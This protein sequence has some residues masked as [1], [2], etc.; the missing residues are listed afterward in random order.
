MRRIRFDDFE[1]DLDL[2]TLSKNGEKIHIGPRALDLL[3]CLTENRERVVSLDFLQR[4]VWKAKSL[5]AA[6]IPTAIM[7]IRRALGDSATAPSFISSTRGRG[8]RFLKDVELSQTQEETRT[9]TISKQLP[10]VGRASQ[11]KLLKQMSDQLVSHSLGRIVVLTGE[12]GIGKTRLLSEFMDSASERVSWASA[13]SPK[14]EGC[15]P[16]WLWTHLLRDVNASGRFTS[17]RLAIFTQALARVFPEVLGPA[18]A[19]FEPPQSIAKFTVIDQWISAIRSM[20]D[21]GPLILTF[22]DIHRADV[23]S[24][25]L[26]ACLAEEVEQDPILIL[27][28][29]RPPTK[30]D[31]KAYRIAEIASAQ[32]AVSMEV[33]ALSASE[34][35]SLFE[36]LRDDREITGEALHRRTRGNAFY[37]SRVIQHFGLDRSRV[38]PERLELEL[39]ANTGELIARQLSDLPQQTREALSAASILGDR[40]STEEVSSLTSLPS[41]EV[42]EHLS[43]AKN[44]SIIREDTTELVF[45]HSIL[46]DA[47]YSELDDTIRTGLHRKAADSI[48]RRPDA[49]QRPAEIA[50]HLERSIPL[51]SRSETTEW[52]LRS[53]REA[54]SRFAY[55]EAVQALTRALRNCEADEM[56]SPKDICAVM[57]ELASAV[58]YDGNREESRSLLFKSASLA[59]TSGL[60]ASLAACALALAP[61]FLTIEVGV[62]D[63]ELVSLLR[64]A[65]AATPESDIALRSKLLGRLSQA[66]QWT[67]PASKTEDL[68]IESL[69]LARK[70]GELDVLVEALAARAESMHGPALA[71][72]RLPIIKELGTAAQQAHSFPAHLL[73]ITR[74]IAAR[75]ELGD[76]RGVEKENEQYRKIA[77]RAA[78]PQ[79]DWYPLVTDAMLA[80]MRGEIDAAESFAI[81]FRDVAGLDPDQNCLQS[82]AGHYILREME[83]DNTA[84]TIPLVE[85]ILKED[86]HMYAWPAAAAWLH[87]ASSDFTSAENAISRLETEDFEK[88]S[89]EPGGGIALALFAEIAVDIEHVPS[90]EPLYELISPLSGRCA[91]LGYGIAYMGSFERYGALLA[92]S[93]G[94][95]DDARS[96]LK[97]ACTAERKRGA[98]S[99]LMYAEASLLHLEADAGTPSIEQI[100][101]ASQLSTTDRAAKLPRA[102][103]ILTEAIKSVTS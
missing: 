53:G 93:L 35:A 91:S 11:I 96:L 45:T 95:I 29:R 69:D 94:K 3:I 70:T 49:L 82:F 85:G 101:R 44:A 81:A 10:F 57:N 1:I 5:S 25:D 75:L 60:S 19:R 79:Y 8:Y 87:W 77:S 86:R 15:P 99:W 59:R 51:S 32:N 58:L 61:D 63:I 28:T 27:A 78:L 39:P 103:R 37:L 36:P 13:R 84:A 92:K 88:M 30:N 12:A 52:L 65:L 18:P 33:P 98:M 22:E 80:L 31:K 50:H 41:I 102:K 68:A 43:P 48:K 17:P 66:G 73:Q 64:E 7:E 76:I 14:F 100:E 97:A 56:A 24:L 2:F 4:E 89:R 6:T 72:A 67:E 21:S 38:S 71:E 54:V 74:S 26:L 40:F 42:L 62:F 9:S 46:R 90:I 34:I 47:L 16:F 83:R 23:D 55:S 20:A